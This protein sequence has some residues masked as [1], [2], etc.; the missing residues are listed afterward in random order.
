MKQNQYRYIAGTESLWVTHSVPNTRVDLTGCRLPYDTQWAQIGVTGGTVTTTPLQQQIYGDTADNGLSRW[1]G[2]LAVDDAGNMAIGYSVANAT[3]NPQIRYSGRLATDP[4]GTLAQGEATL[5]SGGGGQ[6][7]YNRWGDYSSMTL[8]PNGCTFWYTNEYYATT[9]FDWHTRIGSFSFPSCIP[10]TAPGAVV[11]WGC[12]AGTNYG[13]CTIPAGAT[14]GVTAVAAGYSHSLALKSNGSVLAW[15]CTGA[16]YGQCTVPAGAASG[17]TAVAAGLYHS[18]ALKSGSVLSWGCGGGQ[19]YGQCTVPAGAT[20][21]VVA[22]AAGDW[23]SLALKSDGS[24]VAWGCNSF[25]YGQC[26]VPSAALSGVV[27]ID[28]GNAHSLALKNDGSVVAWGCSGFADYGQCTLPAGATGVGRLAAGDYHSLA[29]KSDGSVIAWG[30]IGAGYGQCT[31]PAGASS[32]VSA[33]AAGDTHS[34]ALKTG[35]VIAWGCGAPFDYGQCTVPA[36]AAS[37]VTAIAAGFSHSL[38]IRTSN[39]PTVV[40][41]RAFSASAT[42]DGVRLGWQTAGDARVIG[43]ELYRMQGKKLTRL[44]RKLIPRTSSSHAYSWLDRSAR[45]GVRYQYRLTAVLVDGTRA[46]LAST[47][48]KR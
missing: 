17:V 25:N 15:G 43:F 44:N 28:A 29:L 45:P 23:H 4:P 30:C 6:S 41:L 13:Q 5:F 46:S 1:L 39:G 36:A 12:G 10:K 3:T 16:N 31:V 18:L 47:F 38:A 48:A 11:A 22:I 20:S 33:V 2:S 26:T 35:G 19:D 14:S 9:G 21:S 24:V 32:G 8:D 7:A 42:A 34:L 27:A 40:V 37:S